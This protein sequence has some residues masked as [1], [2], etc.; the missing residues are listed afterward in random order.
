MPEDFK[1]D[2]FV[3]HSAKNKPVA[4]EV[5]AQ[6]ELP[7]VAASSSSATSHEPRANAALGRWRMRQTRDGPVSV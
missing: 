5:A 6:T 1:F 7:R 4:R 2:D 3:N